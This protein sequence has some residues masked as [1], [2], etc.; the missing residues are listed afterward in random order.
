M[1]VDTEFESS[2]CVLQFLGPALPGDPPQPC[3]ELLTEGEAIRYLRLDTVNIS[4]P[5]ATLRRYRE[6]RLLKGTQISKRIFYR[7]AE[8]DRF[9]QSLTGLPAGSSAQTATSEILPG[10]M[11]P[12]EGSMNGE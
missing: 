5:S 1:N 2:S 12:P 8:L 11:E 10:G 6:Q 7:R 3:P 4:D 9:W